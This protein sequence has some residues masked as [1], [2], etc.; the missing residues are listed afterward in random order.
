MQNKIYHKN[1]GL[2][3]K[4]KK[5]MNSNYIN[6]GN[7][8][9]NLIAQNKK[10]VAGASQS[11]RMMKQQKDLGKSLSKSPGGVKSSRKIKK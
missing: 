6:Q 3:D 10:A 8:K 11:I 2:T 1:V 5:A 7:K 4:M 9:P